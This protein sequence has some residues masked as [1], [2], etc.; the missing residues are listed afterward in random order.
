LN[1]PILVGPPANFRNLVHRQIARVR[2]VDVS[3]LSFVRELQQDRRMPDGHPSRGATGCV[4]RVLRPS[5]RGC[6][7]WRGDLL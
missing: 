6:N 4:P 7:S 5:G 1:A 2:G 3:E